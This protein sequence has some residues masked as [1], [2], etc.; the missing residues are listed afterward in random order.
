MQRT[1]SHASKEGTVALLSLPSLVKMNYGC[2][3][4]QRESW[5]HIHFQ[6][7][8]DYFPSHWGQFQ[9][10]QCNNLLFQR[11]VR[12]SLSVLVI[13]LHP[14]RLHN[15]H[16]LALVLLVPLRFC[17]SVRVAFFHFLAKFSRPS[18]TLRCLVKAAFR[19]DNLLFALSLRESQ[20]SE[21]FGPM[22]TWTLPSLT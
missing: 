18:A 11:Q 10:F 2:W 12:C 4:F 14:E 16:R 9:C 7:L 1:G 20:P 22:V 13:L 19:R 5:A 15:V 3:T 21:Q 17:R 6:H 8:M